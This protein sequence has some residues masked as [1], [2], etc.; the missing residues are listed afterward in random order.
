MK[1]S[2]YRMMSHNALAIK[3][4]LIILL[5]TTIIWSLS[6]IC[7]TYFL[8]IKERQR[9]IEYFTNRSEMQVKLYS[10]SDVLTHSINI[11]SQQIP[12]ALVAL[13]LMAL[14]FYWLLH[15]FLLR[16]LQDFAT[17]IGKGG[18]GTFNS[19]LPEDRQDELGCIARAYNHLLDTLRVQYDNVESTIAERTQLL[20]ESRQQ[21]EQ[22]S[23]RKSTH[24]TTISHELRTPLSGVLGAVE[25]L[26]TTHL[27][28]QQQGLANTARQCTLSLLTIINDLLDFSRIESGHFSVH[29]EETKLLPLLDQAMQTIQ[30]PAQSK[31]LVL[32]TYV[33]PQVPL[34]LKTDDVRLRQILVNLLGNS[35][36]FTEN[37]GISLTVKRC[38]Q[39]LIFAVSDSGKGIALQ[40]QKD[41]FTA[42]YQAEADA[43]GTGIGLTIASN[44]AKMM[45]GKLELHSTPGL[46]TCI[47][48]FLPLKHYLSPQP[49]SGKLSAPLTLHR[50]LSAWGITCEISQQQNELNADELRFLPG[51]LYKLAEQKLFGALPVAESDG[52]VSVQ[53]W[54]LHVLLVD[55]AA[56]NRDIIGKMLVSLGQKVT[57]AASGSEA[58]SIAQQQRFDLVLMDIRM[59]GIDGVE[60][61]R[62]W[63]HCQ[64]NQDPQCI[65][66]ALS[67]NA[68][69]EEIIRCK[70]AGIHH[71]L[72]KPVTLANL[73]NSISI[74]AEY[75]LLRNIKL[76][77]QD[78][79]LNCSILSPDNLHTNIRIK[80][81][82]EGLLSELEEALSEGKKI[83]DL[84][85]TL[86]GS[87]GQAGFSELLC[88]VVDMENRARHGL[89]IMPAELS[90]LRRSLQGRLTQCRNN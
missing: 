24:L 53:P 27:N 84:L 39:Q 18:W 7:A 28:T 25:L 62:L 52:N 81:V 20:N 9:L 79:K 71:Y 50:Q 31:K 64:Y 55:D 68:A 47:S 76:Q 73:A 63:R 58:L 11:I 48:F 57:F 1:T 83:D 21:A 13:T 34:Q 43:Q 67:A 15:C 37:G 51:K 82:L 29:S 70:N 30:G 74:A 3:L 85:H 2:I 59:P 8:L 33:G 60:C 6:I 87:L 61:V 72:T 77:E 78:P 54:C 35:L 22:A 42:F 44:L 32:R 80:Q 14:I 40:H 75:Q 23:K 16:P 36:K 45:G 46:G 19:R 41:I 89:K 56:V 65:I 66:V 38:E 17:I 4:T 26:Q 10:S 88:Y 90:D 49:L 69:S 5:S 86:K 12:L